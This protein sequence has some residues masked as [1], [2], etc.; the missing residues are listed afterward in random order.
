VRGPRRLGVWLA[1]GALALAGCSGGGGTAASSSSTAASSSSAAAS[2]SAGPGTYLALGDSVPFGFRGGETP[3]VYGNPANFV[4]YPQLVAQKL[5]LDLVNASCPGE[6]TESFSDTAAQSN[7]C[8]NRA[9]VAGGYRTTFPLHVT[10]DAPDQ[11]QLDFAVRA[12]KNTDDISLITVQLGA[13][14]GF[15]CQA[16]T[17]D[18]CATEVVTVAQTVQQNLTAIL[19][20]LRDQGYDGKIVVVTYYALNYADPTGAA[21]TQLLNAGIT[22]AATARGATVASG[23]DA[24]QPLAQQAGGDSIAAGLVLPNDVHPTAQGQQLLADAVVTAAG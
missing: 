16:S 11:A 8:E 4:G 10:Y 2:S 9:G 18:H 14:D 24:F 19:A 22:S 21:G 3:E 12:V 13:N 1:A 17:P 20:T 5:G 23:F 6:T 15:L 7:G